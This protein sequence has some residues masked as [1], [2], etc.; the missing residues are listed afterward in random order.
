MMKHS[1]PIRRFRINVIGMPGD[2][3]VHLIGVR[4]GFPIPLVKKVL[5]G[6]SP[7]HKYLIKQHVQKNKLLDKDNLVLLEGLSPFSDFS[8]QPLSLLELHDQWGKIAGLDVWHGKRIERI[9]KIARIEISEAI[10]SAKRGQRWESGSPGSNLRD[11]IFARNI[12]AAIAKRPDAAKITLFCGAAHV[13]GVSRFLNDEKFYRT[14]EQ[15]LKKLAPKVY[16]LVLENDSLMHN[17][18]EKNPENWI[19]WV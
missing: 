16:Q 6:P 17:V 11:F 13:P 3:E 14:Y 8:F 15:K 1:E 19:R 18:L 7:R 10:R 12:R 4:H 9:P 5:A 2:R